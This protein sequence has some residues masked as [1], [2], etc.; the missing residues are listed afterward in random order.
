MSLRQTLSIAW[1]LALMAPLASCAPSHEGARLELSVGS[2]DAQVIRAT[3][4]ILYARLRDAS[5]GRLADVRTSYIAETKR[6]VFQIMHSSPGADAL[7]YLYQTR[8]EYRVYETD[9]AGERVDWITNGDIDSA[10]GGRSKRDAKV[11][12][13]LGPQAGLPI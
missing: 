11:F 12:I 13:G 10:S 1:I 5:G 6:L 2:E 7:R 4:Q 3:Q 8:G 9:E